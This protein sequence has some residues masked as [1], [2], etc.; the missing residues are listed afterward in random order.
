MF[1]LNWFVWRL[2]SYE[3]YMINVG[4]DDGLE[5]FG[6]SFGRGVFVSVGVAADYIVLWL[7]ELSGFCWG[8]VA[9][10]RYFF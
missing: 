2:L 5:S 1:F 8:E 6:A 4:I 10:K 7:V 3:W 9:Q